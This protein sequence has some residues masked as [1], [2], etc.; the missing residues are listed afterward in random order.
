[1]CVRDRMATDAPLV[2][3]VM[4]TEGE[5]IAAGNAAGLGNALVLD[6]DVTSRVVI[7]LTKVRPLKKSMLSSAEPENG[8]RPRCQK[9]AKSSVANGSPK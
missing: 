9:F 7:I 3:M 6:T 1:M 5:A 4:G 8:A 2:A